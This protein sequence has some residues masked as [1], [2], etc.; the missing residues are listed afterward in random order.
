[1]APFTLVQP[2][3]HCGK[4]YTPVEASKGQQ[5]FC[6]PEC[7][8]ADEVAAREQ[9]WKI[10]NGIGCGKP[11]QPKSKKHRYCSKECLKRAQNHRKRNWLEPRVCK[12]PDCENEFQPRSRVSFY[13][14]KTCQQRER[15]RR[16]R[17]TPH[18]AEANRR[19]RKNYDDQCKTYRAAY[20]KR[21]YETRRAY[22]IE[23]QRLYKVKKN[24]E[25]A[26]QAARWLEIADPEELSKWATVA[27]GRRVPEWVRLTIE[28]L[29]TAA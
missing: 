14:S 21:H 7:R 9:A 20:R 19:A 23:E 13:C 18:G 1:M 25:T 6:S 8:K 12:A 28:S 17:A 27:F 4:D 29:T 24:E 5:K 26:Q 15:M 22:F 3:E 16:Y 2:C 10:C 11:F